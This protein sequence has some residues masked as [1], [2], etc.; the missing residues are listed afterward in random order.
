MKT[1]GVSH[2]LVMLHC[3]LSLP[4]VVSF[5]KVTI[6]PELKS[7]VARIT[8]NATACSVTCGPGFKLEEMCE[9]TPSGERR[10]CTVERSE[11]LTNWICGLL[12]FTVPAGKP[13]ELRCLDSDAS[14]LGSRGYG[15][16]WSFAHGLVTT[17]D[18]LFKPFKNPGPVVRF[19]AT[20]EADA[21]TYRCDVRK[22]K[23]LKVVKRI[24]FGVRVIQNKLVDL[25][26]EKS[27]TWEQKLA[28]I[29]EE[30]KGGNSTYE[31]MRE[32]QS[33]WQAEL[34]YKCLIAAGIGV[35]VALLVK[36]ALYVLKIFKRR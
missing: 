20:R 30:G 10:N 1:L 31:E 16:T 7:V 19:S 33:F 5:D 17:N 23:T 8:V 4:L 11:C 35:I 13:L 2:I 32:E 14:S 25:D 36:M 15:W 28:A 27:L 24:Y 9:I 21:G 22:L 18:V 34:L 12:H 6:P 3:A 29:K 26:F